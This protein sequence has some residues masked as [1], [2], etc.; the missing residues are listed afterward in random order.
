MRSCGRRVMVWSCEAVWAMRIH[1]CEMYDPMW[2]TEAG[3]GR[4]RTHCWDVR[5]ERGMVWKRGV[6][7]E[8]SASFAISRRS[9]VACKLLVYGECRRLNWVA[10]YSTT[11]LWSLADV[12]GTE[13][14]SHPLALVLECGSELAL[15]GFLNRRKWNPSTDHHTPVKNDVG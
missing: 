6:E 9:S 2:M 1:H 15:D 3:V 10:A 7:S 12:V 5:M 14:L 8:L 4:K 11:S 13:H